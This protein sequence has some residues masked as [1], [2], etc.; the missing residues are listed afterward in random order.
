MFKNKTYLANSLTYLGLVFSIFSVY[1][2]LTKNFNLSIILFILAGICDMLDGKFASYFN[3]TKDEKEFGIQL[4]SM[5]DVVS[6]VI[7]PSIFVLSIKF[8]NLFPC[9][10]Y[11]IAGVTRLTQFTAAAEVD[12]FNYYFKGLPVTYSALILPLTYI[13]I[14]LWFIYGLEMLILALL[15]VSKLKIRKNNMYMNIIFITIA[16]IVMIIL[17]LK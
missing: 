16:L 1:N 3:R 17:I 9:I 12:K 6:F 14:D 5:C 4:D 13:C 11:V 8:Y 10:L 2:I 7:L 15:F